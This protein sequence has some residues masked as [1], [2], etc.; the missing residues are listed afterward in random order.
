M[1]RAVEHDG[2]GTQEQLGNRVPGKISI[3]DLIERTPYPIIRLVEPDIRDTLKRGQDVIPC[4]IGG[5]ND[6]VHDVIGRANRITA[7]AET[8]FPYGPTLGIKGFS[9][10]ESQFYERL[11]GIEA[12]EGRVLPTFGASEAIEI[13]LTVIAGGGGEVLTP[14]PGYVNCL[15]YAQP[16]GARVVPIPRLDLKM[17]LHCLRLKKLNL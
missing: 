15:T 10:A 6:E 1:I 5:T 13:A 8:R 17:D 12:E 14:C 9:G 7:E 2:D 11:Y 4:H 3:S 16:V